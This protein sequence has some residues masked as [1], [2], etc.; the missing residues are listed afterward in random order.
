M[1][2]RARHLEPPLGEHRSRAIVALDLG[3]ATR[4]VIQCGS[5]VIKLPRAGSWKQLLRGLLANLCER[6]F[7]RLGWPELCPVIWA[8][9]LGV[10]VVMP[11]VAVLTA[12]EFAAID[13]HAAVTRPD[14]TSLAD[15]VERKWNSFGWLGGR[16][17]A[18]DYGAI[19][20]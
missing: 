4:V 12:E 13:Y 1:S 8:D 5:I 15:L 6:Q 17:V 20:G 3:G 19:P 18:I 14:G 9:P 7:G 10:I 2:R 11:R 16:V